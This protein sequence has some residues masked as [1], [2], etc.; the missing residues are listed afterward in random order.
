M[1]IDKFCEEFQSFIETSKNF[2]G[3]SMYG[4]YGISTETLLI[5]FKHFYQTG[6]NVLD[7]HAIMTWTVWEAEKGKKGDPSYLPSYEYALCDRKAKRLFNG[8]GFWK[9]EDFC[10]SEQLAKVKEF[11]KYSEEKRR[12]L[13]SIVR[14]KR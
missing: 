14:S 4:M 10:S 2:A 1:E 11:I 6:K 8:K 9:V 7:E 13:K 12:Y 3:H 5:A